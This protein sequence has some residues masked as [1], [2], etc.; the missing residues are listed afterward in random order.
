[1]LKSLSSFL[2]LFFLQLFVADGVII[3]DTTPTTI[4]PGATKN[5]SITINKGSVEG[6]AKL[7]LVLPEGLVASPDQTNGA[8]FTFTDQKAKF[9]W[10]SLPSEQE[11]TI[12]YNLKAKSNASGYQIIKGTFSYIKENQRIDYELQSKVV[13]IGEDDENSAPIASSNKE[14]TS[15]EPSLELPAAILPGSGMRCVRTITDLGNNE[16]IVKLNVVENHLDGFTKI[17]ETIPSGFRIDEEDS[18]GAVVTKD[19]KGIKFVW[20]EAPQMEQFFVSYRLTAISEGSDAPSVLGLFSYVENNAPKEVP[21]LSGGSVETVAQVEPEET[22]EP[23]IIE[24]VVP[25]EPSENN[26]NEFT[27]LTEE[28]SQTANAEAAEAELEVTPEVQESTPEPTV[29]AEVLEEPEVDIK[30]GSTSVQNPEIGVT[31][32]VQIAASHQVVGKDYFK[33]K[34]GFLKPVIIENHKG[35]VKYTTGSHGMYKS[36]RD[37]RNQIRGNYSFRGPFVTAYN[38]GVRIT[39]QEALMIT[40]QKWYK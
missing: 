37:D 26:S 24:E 25:E 36:A 12:S 6:F 3:E 18:D 4:A 1:M 32:R 13:L 7:E 11:F 23:E 27:E 29:T 15:T 34:H 40:K 10:M 39:V 19:D 17:Q 21:V 35:W 9:L 38:D 16:Y 8:S 30:R 5:V 33:R 2:A 28:V 22:A 14:E 31:Y 20:F